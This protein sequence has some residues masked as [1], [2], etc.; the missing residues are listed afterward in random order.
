MDGLVCDI[1]NLYSH[2][3]EILSG[4]LALSQKKTDLIRDNEVDQLDGLIRAEEA[5]LMQL[6]RTESKRRKALEM[7]R[8]EQSLKGPIG[9]T[10][11][12]KYLDDDELEQFDML[13]ERFRNTLSEQQ[14]SSRTNQRLLDTKLK[15]YNHV[16]QIIEGKQ[17]SGGAITDDGKI[18]D[19]RA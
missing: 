3:V 4:F 10:E 11:L 6:S 5:L 14:Q 18:I 16:L 15:Y 7:F 2:Q 1:F 12:R 8:N 17:H 19:T 13:T 9:I